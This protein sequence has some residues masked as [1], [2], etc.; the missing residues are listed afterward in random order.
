MPLNKSDVKNHSTKLMASIES[1]EFP[2]EL[3]VTPSQ[4]NIEVFIPVNIPQ[5]L[6]NEMVK[7]QES[8]GAVILRQKPKANRTYI[9]QGGDADR[10]LNIL[11]WLLKN[12]KTEDG[13][14]L[15]DSDAMPPFPIN[16]LQFLSAKVTPESTPEQ[17]RE[18]E[19]LNIAKWQATLGKVGMPDIKV[20]TEVPLVIG[21]NMATILIYIFAQ[22]S[23]NDFGNAEIDEKKVFKL[24]IPAPVPIAFRKIDSKHVELTFHSFGPHTSQDIHDQIVNHAIPTIQSKEAIIY[25]IQKTDPI[26]ANMV[27]AVAE[28]A[29]SIVS[30][31]VDEDSK[32]D[33]LDDTKVYFFPRNPNPEQI[34]TLDK[35][36]NA[37]FE[38]S[39]VVFCSQCQCVYCPNSKD[40][41]C[42]KTF[43]K[44][45]QV[46]IEPGQMEI[47]DEDEITGEPIILVKYSC[48]GECIKDD[49]PEN[50]G[51]ERF[52]SHLEDKSHPPISSITK[53]IG[54]ITQDQ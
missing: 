29:N 25:D 41:V 15:F 35:E 5:E 50:C 19:E 16:I 23:V 14:P 4:L 51:E 17:I 46:E 13:K 48:C 6:K 27:V 18:I 24:L 31:I 44:G 45:H 47:V 10:R 37:I 33:E 36:M 11:L 21:I 12:L 28:K 26:D 52:N 38:Q 9:L 22:S 43:H 53:T 1:I 40:E 20:F 54:H 30:V 7:M 49:P 2:P 32:K 8:K 3:K 42:I 34:D 39:R